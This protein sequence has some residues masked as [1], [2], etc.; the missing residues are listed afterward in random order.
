VNLRASAASVIALA[1][2]HR[3]P[4]CPAVSK[5]LASMTLLDGCRI[6]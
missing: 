6:V 2:P 5:V 3:R 4:A 1:A